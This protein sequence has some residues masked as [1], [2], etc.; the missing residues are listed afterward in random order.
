V[1]WLSAGML[2]RIPG[3]TDL[4]YGRIA[5]Q[6]YAAS[7]PAVTNADLAVSGDEVWFSAHVRAESIELARARLAEFAAAVIKAGGVKATDAR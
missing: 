7:D 3:L 1:N 4:Q 6:L 5:D 2:L